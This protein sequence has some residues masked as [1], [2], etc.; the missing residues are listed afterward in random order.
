MWAQRLV[1]PATFALVD[2][3]QPREDQLQQGE[4]LL[5]VLAGGICGSDLPHFAGRI[6]NTLPVDNQRQAASVVG[7]PMHEVVGEVMASRSP[8][9]SKNDH[10][11]G[12]ASGAN[13]LAELIIA[14]GAGVN[15]FRDKSLAPTQAII[16]QPLACVLFTLAQIGEIAGKCVAVLGQGPIG[17]LFSHAMKSAGARRVIGVDRVLHPSAGRDFGVDEYV[18]SSSDRWTATLTEH[19][20]PDI[21][22]EA[23][24]HQVGTVTDA[25][26]SVAFGGTVHCFGV[27]DDPVY[28]VPIHTMLRKNMA[29]MSGYV[30]P[31]FRRG[32]I[33]V[34]TRYLE[35][36]PPLA[37]AMVTHVF[38]Y[39]EAEEAYRRAS[40]PTP[41]QHKVVVSMLL[42]PH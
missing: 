4:V 18:H 41:E 40:S 21:V 42:A 14:D 9:L 37:E 1:A 24:G 32:A 2:V 39:T 29:L 30:T 35:R 8:G 13:A 20:R 17:L 11:V 38:V 19:E 5:K 36:H 33:D 26:Q 28:P 6:S 15:I 34:A 31:P 25:I 7:Y 27:P 3:P 23:I 22:V 12:W 16:A 10:V